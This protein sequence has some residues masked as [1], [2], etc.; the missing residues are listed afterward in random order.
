VTQQ[1]HFRPGLL[2]FSFQFHRAVQVF[3]LEPQECSVPLERVLQESAR[4]GREHS[5]EQEQEPLLA[6]PVELEL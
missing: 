3:Q 5:S 4:L 2:Q 6:V 1:A